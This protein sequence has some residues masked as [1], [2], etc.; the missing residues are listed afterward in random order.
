MCRTLF[1]VPPPKAR[2]GGGPAVQVLRG[3]VSALIIALVA[4]ALGNATSGELLRAAPDKGTCGQQLDVAHAPHASP[5]PVRAAVPGKPAGLR[6]PGSAALHSRTR[7]PSAGPLWPHVTLLVLLVAGSRWH[8]LPLGLLLGFSII[9][10][11]AAALTAVMPA[12][13]CLPRCCR[14]QTRSRKPHHLP[15]LSCLARRPLAGRAA[16]GGAPAPTKL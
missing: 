4:Y 7:N 3:L 5:H 9:V 16:V 12:P 11:D 10:R 6:A 14:A 15:W 2:P 1:S 13:R 8:W